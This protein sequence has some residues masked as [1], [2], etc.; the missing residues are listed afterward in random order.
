MFAES[1]RNQSDMDTVLH[2]M[3]AE[4]F[5]SP[6]VEKL[7]PDM[8]L[9]VGSSETM[10]PGIVPDLPRPDKDDRVF[11]KFPHCSGW[12]TQV[13]MYLRTTST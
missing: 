1:A 7:V 2:R 4:T 10:R 11:F 3:E 13:C 6:E 12:R 5:D 8:A 9:W